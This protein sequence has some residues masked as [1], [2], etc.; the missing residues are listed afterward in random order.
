MGHLD[1]SAVI[2]QN[3]D[4][5]IETLEILAES[6]KVPADVNVEAQGLL[7]KVK[8]PQFALMTDIVVKLLT[9]MK[10]V[11]AMLQSKTCNIGTVD[12]WGS[13]FGL[14]FSL[15]EAENEAKTLAS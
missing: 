7:G 12:G 3:R 11:N 14:V 5:I 9:V 6:W 4:E 1:C 2:K 15:Y 8:K 13:S 10:P